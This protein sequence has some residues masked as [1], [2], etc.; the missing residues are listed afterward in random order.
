MAATV[1]VAISTGIALSVLAL[2]LSAYN[3]ILLRDA[4][5]EAASRAARFGSPSQRPYLLRRIESDLPMLSSVQID[6]VATNG[7]I[8]YQ[9]VGK[10]LGLGFLPGGEVSVRAVVA[11][12]ILG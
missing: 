10:T 2:G 6:E 9:V 3:T 7:S 1:A 12:E 11:K 4:A 8:G 5:I